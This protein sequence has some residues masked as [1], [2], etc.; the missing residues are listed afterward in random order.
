MYFST[1]FFEEAGLAADKAYTLTPVLYG[2]GCLGTFVSWFLVARFGRKTL[3]MAGNAIMGTLL[4]AMGVAGIFSSSSEV[5]RWYVDCKSH[6]NA[7][8]DNVHTGLP[9][10]F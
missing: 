6:Y 5:A 4:F 7:T 1:V 3:Y 9:Q 10:S 2:V 8:T